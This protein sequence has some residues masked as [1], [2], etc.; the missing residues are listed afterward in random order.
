MGIVREVCTMTCAVH[1]RTFDHTLFPHSDGTR[2]V[3]YEM[4]TRVLLTN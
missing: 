4:L 2:N 3:K 1:L